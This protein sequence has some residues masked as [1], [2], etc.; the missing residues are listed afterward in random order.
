M[1]NEVAPITEQHLA[2]LLAVLAAIDTPSTK[3][4]HIEDRRAGIETLMDDL[5]LL[6]KNDGC[7]AAAWAHETL[8][9]IAARL[10]ELDEEA[11]WVRRKLKLP[12]ETTL[13]TTRPSLAGELHVVCADRHGMEAYTRAYKC[14]DK[15]GEIARLVAKN[16]ALNVFVAAVQDA[17]G[18]ER[19]FGVIT[20]VQ[21]A[22]DL[23]G[24]MQE[25]MKDQPRP[26]ALNQLDAGEVTHA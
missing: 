22:L 24:Q 19:E 3:G 6:A 25:A 23:L 26:E 15:Q 4:M 10:R 13:L 9:A 21:D 2:E 8:L 11:E 18:A 20:R 5:M 16:E 7:I 12:P 1:S 17:L 14:D